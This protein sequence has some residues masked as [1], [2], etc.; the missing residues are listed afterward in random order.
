MS[1]LPQIQI[2]TG[3]NTISFKVIYMMR[4]RFNVERDSSYTICL[5]VVAEA[6]FFNLPL[7]FTISFARGGRVACCN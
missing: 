4:F 5:E 7:L 1:R 2:T 6:T 3:L